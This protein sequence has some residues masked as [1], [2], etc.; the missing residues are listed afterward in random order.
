MEPSK[1]FTKSVSSFLKE[2][3]STCGSLLVAGKTTTLIIITEFLR[4]TSGSL[5]LGDEDIGDVLSAL[6]AVPAFESA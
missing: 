2:S 3:S 5:T 1:P 6:L 4:P